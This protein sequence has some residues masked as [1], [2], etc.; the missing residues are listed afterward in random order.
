MH[1][2][3]F[4]EEGIEKDFLN[5]IAKFLNIIISSLLNAI[6]MVSV[7]VNTGSKSDLLLLWV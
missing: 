2:G 1:C 5:N 6:V 4:R 7:S 3:S